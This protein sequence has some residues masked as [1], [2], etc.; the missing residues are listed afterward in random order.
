MTQTSKPGRPARHV[1][2]FAILLTALLA[3]RAF[4]RAQQP[5][6][7]AVAA[8]T[9]AAHD[10]HQGLLVAADPYLTSER[11]QQTF[12]KKHP[13][14]AG[15]LAL[16]VYLQNDTDGPMRV[17]LDTVELSVAPPGQARQRIEPLTAEDAA[18]RIVLPDGP[19]PKARRGPLPGVGGPS[20]KSKEVAKMEDSLRGQMLPGDVVGPHATVHGFVFFDLDGHFGWVKGSTLVVPDVARIGTGE[21]LLFF[22]VDLAPATR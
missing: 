14:G 15:L 10:S 2:L 19:Q 8:S 6:K 5:A 3:P 18:F 11:S 1:A 4:T 22:E 21:K 13:Y 7:P 12:G 20:K 9:L 17:T 16:D